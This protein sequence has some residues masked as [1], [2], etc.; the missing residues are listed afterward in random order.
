MSTN[1]EMIYSLP[2]DPSNRQIR[3]LTLTS[4]VLEEELYCALRTVSPTPSLEYTALS[5]VWGD[6]SIRSPININGETTSIA[7]NLDIALRNLWQKEGQEVSVWADGICINQ[8]D[9]SEKESQV[10]IMG[11]VYSN[12]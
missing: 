12:G 6:E 2:L 4:S 7:T 5:Y 3:L 8:A 9:D 10:Q 11:D 1:I